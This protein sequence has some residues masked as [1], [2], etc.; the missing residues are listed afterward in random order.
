M[1][2]KNV[3]VATQ[4]RPVLQRKYQR[5]IGGINMQKPANPCGCTHTHTHTHTQLCLQDYS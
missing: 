3:G 5:M 4:G 1:F 2:Y